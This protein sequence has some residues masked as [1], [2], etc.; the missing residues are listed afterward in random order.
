VG[1]SR[2]KNYILLMQ[3]SENGSRLAGH[4]GAKIALDWLVVIEPDW[5]SIGWK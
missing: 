3:L 1:A 5:L 4:D 2:R